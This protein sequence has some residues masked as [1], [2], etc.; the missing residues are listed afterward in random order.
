MS[1]RR[2]ADRHPLFSVHWACHHAFVEDAEYGRFALRVL[3]P[4]STGVICDLDFSMVEKPE[5]W[6]LSCEFNTDL[7]DETTVRALLEQYENLL[8]GVVTGHW[9]TLSDLPLLERGGAPR[10]DRRL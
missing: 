3:P 1:R 9:R 6:Q 10:P 2:D 7:F 8:R 4:R 5:G